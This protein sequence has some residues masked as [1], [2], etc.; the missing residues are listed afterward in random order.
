M[1]RSC[2]VEVSVGSYVIAA[3]AVNLGTTSLTRCDEQ[4]Q[5]QVPA[6]RNTESTFSANNMMS[7]SRWLT[8]YYTFAKGHVVCR[9]L[10]ADNYQS[11][12]ESCSTLVGINQNVFQSVTFFLVNAL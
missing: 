9:T 12:K 10:T 7:C 4:K 3:R 1:H 11:K 5:K 8:G 2:D 6:P